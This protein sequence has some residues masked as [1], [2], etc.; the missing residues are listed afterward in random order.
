LAT[1][2]DTYLATLPK[3]K[4]DTLQKLRKSIKAAAPSAEEAITYGIPGF[5][6]RGKPLVSYNAAKEHC[7]LF[8]MSNT[9]LKPFAKDLKGYKT[10]TGTVRFLIGSSLP[11]TLVKRLV[12]ARMAETDAVFDKKKEK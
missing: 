9:A 2:V 8:V 6:Y 5:R 10:S 11:A 1:E 7:S 4:R 3:D 12:K